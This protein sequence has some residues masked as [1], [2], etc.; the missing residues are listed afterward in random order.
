MV[1]VESRQRARSIVQRRGLGALANDTKWGEFFARVR[2]ESIPVEV[3][4]IDDERVF[5]CG[6]VWSPV[7]NYIEGGGGMGPVLY[8]FVEWVRSSSVEKMQAAAVAIGLEY[9]VNNGMATVYG[10]R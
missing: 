5:K 6:V 3:K 8:I 7:T 9:E 10:Y 2:E 1:N 4:L